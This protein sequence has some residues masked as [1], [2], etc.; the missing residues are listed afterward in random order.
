VVFQAS[1]RVRG[2]SED[3]PL[4]RR[5]NG[6]KHTSYFL[7]LII[8]VS[9]VP[10]AHLTRILHNRH[11]VHHSTAIFQSSSMYRLSWPGKPNSHLWKSPN[12]FR[13]IVP[14]E[15]APNKVKHPFVLG[16]KLCL[17]ILIQERV[18]KYEKLVILLI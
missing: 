6:S 1:G 17:R 12:Y 7:S 18:S 10:C 14:L 5:Q 4:C 3:I 15:A 8:L 13:L 16:K 2:K 9:L 11:T